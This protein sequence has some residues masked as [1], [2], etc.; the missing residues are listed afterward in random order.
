MHKILKSA[1]YLACIGFTA[2]FSPSCSDDDDLLPGT[3]VDQAQWADI[4]DADL[5][6]E[7]LIYEF[8]APA[9]WTASCIDDWCEVLTPLGYAGKS[10]LRLKVAPNDTPYGRQTTVNI[11]ISGYADPIALLI[12]QGEGFI[13]KGDGIYRDV[14]EWTYNYMAANYLWNEKVPDLLLDHSVDYQAFLK[15]I[16]DGVA[17]DN[18]ANHDDGYWVDGK[19]EAY[20]TYLESSAPLSRAAGDKYTDSGIAIIPT[21]LGANEDDPCGFAVRWVTPG[22]PADE[23]GVRR[24]DFITTVNKILGE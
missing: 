17:A 2:I 8:D 13:E 6:G 11:H 15:S 21:I 12:R 20:Y 24:G 9:Y 14:N 5:M 19:R 1:L 4:N 23:A 7:I 10:S 18:D 22:S 16:L 3:G